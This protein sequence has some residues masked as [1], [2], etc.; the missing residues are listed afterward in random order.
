MKTG[1]TEGIDLGSDQFKTI[2]K[3]KIA[4]I[5]G[6]G[7]RSYDAGE[8]WHLFD[9]K[10]NIPITKIDVDNINKLNLDKYSSLIGSELFEKTLQA[11]SISEEDKYLS[12]KNLVKCEC[13]FKILVCFD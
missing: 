12:T 4:L 8:I 5:V 13:L 11:L 1:A 7:V 10:Y 2:E 3:P 6:D 9:I